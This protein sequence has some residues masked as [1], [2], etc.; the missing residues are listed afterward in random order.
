MLL[1]DRDQRAYSYYIEVRKITFDTGNFFTVSFNDVVLQSGKYRIK[2]T[3]FRSVLWIRGILARIRIRGSVPQEL[4]I[5]ILLF[6]SGFQDF[7]KISLFF[8]SFLLLFFVG[9]FP[10]FFKDKKS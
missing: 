4:R 5:R 9:T 6:F 2:I 7:K 10:S 1:W 8:L 3:F